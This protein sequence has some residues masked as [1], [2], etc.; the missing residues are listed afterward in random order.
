VASTE[1]SAAVLPNLTVTCSSSV[2][3]AKPTFAFE[4]E[5]AK[6]ILYDEHDLSAAEKQVRRLQWVR[7]LA[8]SA[9]DCNLRSRTPVHS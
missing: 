9:E 5:N 3:V 2:T 1:Q 4:K 6:N 8:C 7:F